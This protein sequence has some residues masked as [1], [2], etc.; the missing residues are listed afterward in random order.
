MLWTLFIY[1]IIYLCLITFFFSR[2][3]SLFLHLKQIPLCFPF[4]LLSLLEFGEIVTYPGLER[5][6]LYGSIYMQPLECPV[7][8]VGVGS[9]VAWVTSPSPPGVL[10][11]THTGEGVGWRDEEGWRARTK[12]KPWASIVT[13]FHH[14]LRVRLGAHSDGATTL[15]HSGSSCSVDS[16]VCS[17]PWHFTFTLVESSTGLRGGWSGTCGEEWCAL[18]RSP[19]C[20]WDPRAIFYILSLFPLWSG[21]PHSIP[22]WVRVHV[23][24]AS[25]KC[26]YLLCQ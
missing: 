9:E 11:A 7:A 12:W 21:F 4:C 6:S 18:G 14:T 13:G 20:Q 2:F 5:V 15:T 22:R 23:G 19:A 8:L 17:I 16:Q 24:S 25:S 10:M 1:Y 26:S 3:F